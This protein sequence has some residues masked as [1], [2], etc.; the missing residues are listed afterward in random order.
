MHSVEAYL[1]KCGKQLRLSG[2]LAKIN[3]LNIVIFTKR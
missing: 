3:G 2:K 1:L